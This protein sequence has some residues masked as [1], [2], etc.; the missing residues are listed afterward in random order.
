M[1]VP[2]IGEV[3]R[4]SPAADLQVRG[5][6][7]PK[8]CALAEIQRSKVENVTEST[9]KLRQAVALSFGTVAVVAAVAV[10]RTP[11]RWR[12]RR[13]GLSART[14]QRRHARLLLTFPFL[15]GNTVALLVIGAR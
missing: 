7:R 8:A 4:A 3:D 15:S 6:D 14:P 10:V 11:L 9:P 5:V 1:I 12:W 2:V 13:R